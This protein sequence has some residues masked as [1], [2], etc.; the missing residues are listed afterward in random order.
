[1]SKFS[2]RLTQLREESGLVQEELSSRI[3]EK[4]ELSTNRGMISKWEKGINVPGW[5]F[6]DH[7]ADFFGVTTDFLS[8]RS[9]NK[10]YADCVHDKKIPVLGTI[11]ARSPIT[12]QENIIGYEY[13]FD[14]CDFCLKVKGD[15]MIGARICDG[16]TIFIH[17]QPDVENG[18]I[19]AV[20]IDGEEATLK[21][22]Y[23]VNGS[24]ILHAENPSYK[25][26]IYSKKDFKQVK[27]LG[28]ARYIKTEVR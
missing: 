5:T 21:R 2:E 20:T 27:I 28:K 10:Y 3:N 9:D 25:D 24:I 19:A 22:V 7:L 15:S 8:G 26:L 14:N 23:K 13:T 1:M 4:Y 12:V 18:E 16:D 17:R 6:V 11:S